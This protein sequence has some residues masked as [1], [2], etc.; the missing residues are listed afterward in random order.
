MKPR[1]RDLSITFQR[2][3]ERRLKSYNWEE[4]QRL[5]RDVLRTEAEFIPEKRS[6]YKLRNNFEE[7]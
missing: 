1:L 7:L 5:D 3:G 4:C 2:A 6:F